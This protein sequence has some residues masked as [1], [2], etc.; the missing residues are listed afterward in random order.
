MIIKLIG[1]KSGAHCNLIRWGK[2]FYLKFSNATF[3]ERFLWIRSYNSDTSGWAWTGESQNCNSEY[4]KQYFPC[5]THHFGG[6]V[7]LNWSL[8]FWAKVH[9]IKSTMTI[10]VELNKHCI[11]LLCKLI[12]LNRA[13]VQLLQCTFTNCN[14]ACSC[15]LYL[16]VNF[17]H[18]LLNALYKCIIHNTHVHVFWL[19]Y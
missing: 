10:I 6:E 7:E 9:T 16:T 2:W 4:F 3:L 8:S 1:L 5:P 19:C 14:K 18:L 15:D 17:M 13:T 12:I 11:H